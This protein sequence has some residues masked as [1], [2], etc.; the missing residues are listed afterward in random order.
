[1]S[2]PI[3]RNRPA[4]P[5]RPGRKR[6]PLPPHK[7]AAARPARQKRRLHPTARHHRVGWSIV[8][9]VLA[10]VGAAVA[11]V[12]VTGHGSSSSPRGVAVGD[13][14][15]NGSFTTV[16]R[17]TESVSAFRVVAVTLGRA[18]RKEGNE[19]LADEELD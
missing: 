12:R 5:P 4:V 8:A 3:A 14:A 9:A 13:S 6:P 11:A 7:G 16:A 19:W 10:A 18:A 15:P 17:T 1:M 2:K